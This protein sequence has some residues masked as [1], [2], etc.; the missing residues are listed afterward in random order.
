MFQENAFSY[1]DFFT[2]FSNAKSLFH[3]KIPYVVTR[4]F[5][6]MQIYF[7]KQFLN[8]YLKLSTFYFVTCCVS[9]LNEQP[10]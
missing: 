2:L 1:C 3:F 5:L 7:C 6:Y 4:Q 8:R 10:K 9:L